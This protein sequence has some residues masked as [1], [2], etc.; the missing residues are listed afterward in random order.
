MFH[1]TIVLSERRALMKKYYEISSK[2]SLSSS[3]FPRFLKT[4]TE[5]EIIFLQNVL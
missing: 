3:A 2:V 4:Y 5:E 1:R